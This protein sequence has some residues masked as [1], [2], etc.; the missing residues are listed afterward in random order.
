[1]TTSKHYHLVFFLRD[2]NTCDPQREQWVYMHKHDLLAIIRVVQLGTPTQSNILT[3]I[4]D[5]NAMKQWVAGVGLHAIS[6]DHCWATHH[7]RVCCAAAHQTG[8]RNWS[9][10]IINVRVP[11]TST[12]IYNV[13]LWDKDSITMRCLCECVCVCGWDVNYWSEAASHPLT[14]HILRLLFI[15]L[16]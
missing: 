16:L 3:H 11:A 6:K 5:D 1:M 8:I 13:T 15:F 2:K 9:T 14:T 12:I 10:Y 7:E 4:C